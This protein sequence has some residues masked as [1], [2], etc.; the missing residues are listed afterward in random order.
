MTRPSLY[1][2]Y[3]VNFSL[4]IFFSFLRI[5]LRSTTQQ[6]VQVTIWPLVPKKAVHTTQMF[7]VSVHVE[8]R[9]GSYTICC[10]YFFLHWSL[11]RHERSCPWL[12]R[13]E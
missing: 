1:S 5:L 6:D 13:F 12:D 9:M 11:A 3:M 10:I 2:S 8:T 4:S 7:L